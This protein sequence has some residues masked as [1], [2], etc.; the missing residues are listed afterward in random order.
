MLYKGSM[1][2]CYT[3]GL[4]GQIDLVDFV[5]HVPQFLQQLQRAVELIQTHHVQLQALAH[6]RAVEHGRV[7]LFLFYR[8]HNKS[9]YI[10]CYIKGLSRAPIVAKH[11]LLIPQTAID[12]SMKRNC[13]TLKLEISYPSERL[14][15]Q[16]L[17]ARLGRDRVMRRY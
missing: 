13:S 2:T 7:Q 10:E 14:M 3:F 17:N 6:V 4:D 16:W 5:L 9:S 12:S 11:M 8:D 1:G 15:K